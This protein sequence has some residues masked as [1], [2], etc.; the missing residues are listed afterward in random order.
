MKGIDVPPYEEDFTADP[1]ELFF[2]LVFVFAFSRLV[3]HLVHHPDW[4]GVG[5]F[6]L[7]MAMIWLPWTQFTW[8]AN[9]VAGNSR[10][11]RL[12]F[13][14]ATV[15]SVPMAGGVESALSGTGN[16]GAL[17]AISLSVILAMALVMMIWGLA[18]FPDARA[19]IIR[20][21]VPNW[22]A[23]A[24]MVVGGFLDRTPRIVLWI[25]AIVVIVIGTVR[26]GS[27]EWVVR[28]GHFAERHGLILIVALGEVIV[29][30]GIPVVD[31][32][33]ESGSL[34]ARTIVALVAAGTFAGLLWWSFFDRPIRAFEH[35]HEQAETPMARGRFARD[36]YTYAFLPIVAGVILSAAALEEITLH[37]DDELPAAFRW[38]LAAGLALNQLGIVA[39]VA[40]AFGRVA[41]ERFAA[42][43]VLTTA[44]ALGGSLSG[45]SLLVLVDV[46]LLAMLV[47]EH[48][49][50]EQRFR[51]PVAQNVT[52]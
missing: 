24:L 6:A 12:M 49:R 30:L 38:M 10:P 15:A 46:V 14:V 9:A 37:P 8:S 28:P 1:V 19:S 45:L 48:L 4:T 50:V 41:F 2:D 5:E 42:V 22:I 11:V 35:R 33:D 47:V 27:S 23:I 36:V 20:Y 17:F 26:A 31:A 29:A 13:L 21:S 3:Y 52:N 18:G 40:R 43:V 32:L 51:E 7:L 39:A 34:P 16:A 44:L 25:A